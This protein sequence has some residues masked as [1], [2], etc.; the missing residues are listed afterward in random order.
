MSLQSVKSKVQKKETTTQCHT[1][2]LTSLVQI[3]WMAKNTE[4]LWK[5][6]RN[7]NDSNETIE[8]QMMTIRIFGNLEVEIRW[9]E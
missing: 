4:S 2:V 6:M 3:K 8:I 9:L 7:S 5:S 1:A